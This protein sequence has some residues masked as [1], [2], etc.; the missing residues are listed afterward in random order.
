MNITGQDIFSTRS[1]T[2][3]FIGIVPLKEYCK[4]V[5]KF[6]LI[7]VYRAYRF[8]DLSYF[9]WCQKL[10][11]YAKHYCDQHVKYYQKNDLVPTNG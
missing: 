2:I 11:W 3:V 7:G 1:V 5:A 4:K 10:F 8:D 9:S 6:Y